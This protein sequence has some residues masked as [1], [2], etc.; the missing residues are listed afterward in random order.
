MATYTKRERKTWQVSVTGRSDLRKTFEERQQALIYTKQLT[1]NG[2]KALIKAQHCTA[3]QFRVRSKGVGRT[4]TK[5]FD[6]K[7]AAEAWVRII[8]GDIAKRMFIDYAESER[9]TLGDLLERYR[10]QLQASHPDSPDISRLKKMQRHQVCFIRMSALQSSDIASYRDDRLRGGYRPAG[11]KGTTSDAAWAP[12]KGTTVKRELAVLSMVINLAGREWNVLLPMNPASGRCVS[13]PSTQLGDERTRRLNVRTFAESAER[14]GAALQAPMRSR[15]KKS[16]I[17]YELDPRTLEH[18]GSHRTER[19]LLMTALRYPQWFRPRKAKVSDA[20]QRARHLVAA[21]PKIKA[22]LQSTARLWAC[23]SFALETGVRRR[24]QLELLWSDVHLG[25]GGGYVELRSSTTK[26]RKTRQVPLTLRARRILLTQPRIPGSDRVF[27]TTANAIKMGFSHAREKINSF[28]LRWHDLR[29]EATS[30]F[31][32]QTTLR[33]NE[34]AMITGHVTPRM[35]Q[36]YYNLRPEE[37]VQRFNESWKPR[38]S[39]T[40]LR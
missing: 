33:A 5:T 35:L 38:A 14:V 23:C 17:D 40:P 19:Q 28:D 15:R 4:L 3:W 11:A 24:E 10:A 29:H 27:N 9:L 26:T 2:L 1:E 21:A 6:S 31:F 13:R 22:R 18:I 20:T 34:I 36:R 30:R 37:F 25:V 39:S 8:E 7:S 32:E 16:D 12:V